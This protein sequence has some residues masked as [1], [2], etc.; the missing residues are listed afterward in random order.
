MSILDALYVRLRGRPMSPDVPAR[1]FR[2]FAITKALQAV[3]GLTLPR[4]FTDIGPRFRARGVVLR[5]PQ[6]I[7]IEAGTAL[8]RG[9]TIDGFAQRGVR[10]GKN[11]TVGA[12]AEIRGSG[13]I[14]EPGVGVRVGDRTAVGRANVIW[15]QG[16]VTIGRDCLLGPNVTIVSENHRFDSVAVPIREQGHDRAPVVIGDDCWIGAGAV[17][18]KGVTIGSGAVIAAGAVV[19]KDVPDHAVVAG[20]PAR[21]RADR[22]QTDGI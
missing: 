1:V 16:G 2:Q 7:R 4:R 9:V 6:Y 13:V 12:G 22:K 3:G 17:V 20:V 19:T 11:V 15:G 18:L 8:D 21:L 5:H 14:A 10:L